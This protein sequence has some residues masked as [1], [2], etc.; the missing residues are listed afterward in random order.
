M[1]IVLTSAGMEIDPPIDFT[2]KLDVAAYIALGI[3]ILRMSRLAAAGALAFYLV[4]RLLLKSPTPLSWPI[5]IAVSL[6]FVN[7]I[8]ATVA[9]HRFR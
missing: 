2:A 8:R 7:S 9:Y 3:G 1:L 5:V 6:A 4:E